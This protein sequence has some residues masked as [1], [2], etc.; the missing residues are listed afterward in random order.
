MLEW[1]VL[2]LR[3]VAYLHLLGLVQ[4]FEL[5]S[6]GPQHVVHTMQQAPC[7]SLRPCPA[8]SPTSALPDLAC[9][10]VIY[11]GALPLLP[12]WQ[13][14]P[15]CKL[16]NVTCVIS[17][18]LGLVFMKHTYAGNQSL[19]DCWTTTAITVVLCTITSWASK[20]CTYRYRGPFIVNKCGR[21]INR[22][23]LQLLQVAPDPRPPR[24]LRL[25]LHPHL[26]LHAV[27]ADCTACTF[28]CCLFRAIHMYQ[29]LQTRYGAL[30]QGQSTWR[31]HT[32]NSKKDR[33]YNALASQQV[34]SHIEEE[35]KSKFENPRQI[36]KPACDLVA[37]KMTS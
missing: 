30:T 3:V 18:R 26:H 24:R 1:T 4:G 27:R 16:L 36:W 8:Q 17:G 20:L 15:A 10:A 34:W 6:Q 14:Q 13:H 12:C 5:L 29:M 19:Q 28:T 23:L 7:L 35:T 32:R 37:Q 22:Y 21:R 9:I 31:C 11:A 2:A 33:D 25:V